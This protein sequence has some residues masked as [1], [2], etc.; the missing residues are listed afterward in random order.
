MVICPY[1]LIRDVFREQLCLN[2]VL[3]SIYLYVQ[4]YVGKS[5]TTLKEKPQCGLNTA[6][7]STV[8]RSCYTIIGIN[9]LEAT[10]WVWHSFGFYG[11]CNISTNQSLINAISHPIQHRTDLFSDLL[12]TQ[13]IKSL[14][15]NY[16]HLSITA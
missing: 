15:V 9:K 11:Y 3:V 1:D 4:K 12:K 13:M 2:V 16:C 7:D 14:L 10:L 6:F 8:T 5:E